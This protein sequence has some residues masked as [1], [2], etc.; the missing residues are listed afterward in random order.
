MTDHVALRRLTDLTAEERTDL[1]LGRISQDVLWSRTTEHVRS[2]CDVP[3]A[4]DRVRDVLQAVMDRHEY[5][6]P[7]SRPASDAWVAPRLHATLR[8]TPREAALPGFFTGLAALEFDDYVRWRWADSEGNVAAE[9]YFGSI[10]K[11]VLA[12]LWWGAELLRDGADY[13]RSMIFFGNQD[14]PSSFLHRPFMRFRP[15]ASSVVASLYVRCVSGTPSSDE[16]N[17]VA[18]AV[19]LIALP[20]VVGSLY[21]ERQ[22]FGAYRAWAQS[23]VEDVLSQEPKGPADGAG[24]EVTAAVRELV[25]RI[26]DTQEIGKMSNAERRRRRR[27]RRNPVGA[28]DSEID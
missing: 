8:I 3:L 14:F 20:Y 17:D 28:G 6:D 12:R 1:R 23:E 10:N 21:E 15:L 13:R 16:I 18:D 24:T 9:R 2:W 4:L 7:K 22:D 25:Q 5:S 19:N 26:L 27:A 11:Q